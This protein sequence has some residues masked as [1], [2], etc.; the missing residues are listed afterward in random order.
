MNN[1]LKIEEAFRE[2]EQTTA[3]L[4]FIQTAFAEGCSCINMEEASNAIFMLYRKQEEALSK[5]K[6]C[7]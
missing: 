3:L 5:I 6:E 4:G 2:L 7:F 1:M